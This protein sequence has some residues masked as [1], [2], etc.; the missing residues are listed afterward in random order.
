MRGFSKVDK[1]RNQCVIT[2]MRGSWFITGKSLFHGID[3]IS[4]DLRSQDPEI[5]GYHNENNAEQETVTVF[6]EV[7]I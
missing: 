3:H 4:S 5:V 7:L 2:S 1:P 6:P